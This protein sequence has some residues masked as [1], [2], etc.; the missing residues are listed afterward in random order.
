M[1]IRDYEFALDRLITLYQTIALLEPN[2]IDL[3]TVWEKGINPLKPCGTA[4]CI[5]GYALALWKPDVDLNNPTLDI[6][7]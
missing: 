4:G 3:D 1:K 5:A 6:G 7:F 2:K